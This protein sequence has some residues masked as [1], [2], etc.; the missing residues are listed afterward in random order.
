MSDLQLVN[1][2]NNPIVPKVKFFSTWC[3]PVATKVMDVIHG[4]SLLAVFATAIWNVVLT[5][6]GQAYITK[7][8]PIFWTTLVSALVKIPSQ[9]CAAHGRVG[10]WLTVVGSITTVIITAIMIGYLTFDPAYRNDDPEDVCVITKDGKQYPVQI[11]PS[12]LNKPAT[13]NICPD[14]TMQSLPRHKKNFAHWSP[15]FHV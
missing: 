13:T 6:Q 15:I 12:D 8:I 7:M 5:V 14:K 1:A 10:G 11:Q 4:I 3:G 2:E 9:V